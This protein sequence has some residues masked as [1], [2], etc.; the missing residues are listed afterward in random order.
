MPD[1]T[2][3]ISL[4]SDKSGI[5]T[6]GIKWILNPYDE[7]AVEEAIQL[8]TANSDAILKV[9]SVGPAKRVTTAV[10]TALAMGADEGIVVDTEL[11]LCPFATAKALAAAIKLDGSADQVFTGKL[12][13]DDNASSVSQ[14]LAE[15]L[16]IPHATVVSKFERAGEKTIVER[17]VEGGNKEIIELTGANVV[18]ANKGLNKPRHA[19]LPNIM[20]AKKKPVKELKLDELNVTAADNKVSYSQ[21]SLPPEKAPV[22]MIEGDAGAQAST[23]A[24]LLRNEARVI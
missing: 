21:F 5:E 10:R 14:I 4:K 22:K 6:D 3:N 17:E 24:N 2:S 20:K 19:S 9:V 16:E 8:K 13:I 11:E 12:A 1:T 15:L 18:A 23:L 7:Y